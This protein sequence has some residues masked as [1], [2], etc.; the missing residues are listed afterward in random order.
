MN[1]ENVVRQE[2]TEEVKPAGKTFA[3]VGVV[4]TA[5]SGCHTCRDNSCQNTVPLKTTGEDYNV[6]ISTDPART[7]FLI[8]ASSSANIAAGD[9]I[10]EFF[11][12]EAK[13]VK[14]VCDTFEW[15]KCF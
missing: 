12:D 11:V 14:Y 2:E 5:G 3:D 8:H 15:F 7:E 4:F 6:H 10:E 9:D 13:A 1:P